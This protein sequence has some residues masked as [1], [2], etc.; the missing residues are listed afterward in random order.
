M[1]YEKGSASTLHHQLD[2]KEFQLKKQK[3]AYKY[4]PYI[5]AWIMDQSLMN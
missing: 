4:L 2:I 1:N 5:I 3:N